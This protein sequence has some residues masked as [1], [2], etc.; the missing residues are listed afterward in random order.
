MYQSRIVDLLNSGVKLEDTEEG[1]A[2]IQAFE[3]WEKQQPAPD[4]TDASLQTSPTLP[5]GTSA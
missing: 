2:A 4:A 1:R 5:A 3:E